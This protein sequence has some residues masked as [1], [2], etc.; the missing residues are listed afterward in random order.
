MITMKTVVRYLTAEPFRPFRINMVSG[1]SYEI[2]H[3]EM[4][5]VSKSTVHVNTWW[6]DD[7]MGDP[8]ERE[9]DLSMLL[10]ESLEPL[11]PAGKSQ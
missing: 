11:E 1:K 8:K 2:R 5:A 3:P 7:E 6:E 4:I 9:H 10:I